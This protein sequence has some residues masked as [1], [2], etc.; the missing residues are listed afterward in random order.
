MGRAAWAEPAAWSALVQEAAPPAVSATPDDVAR[1]F[2]SVRGAPV[3]VVVKSPY[4]YRAALTPPWRE[5][6]PAQVCTVPP[7]TTADDLKL[8]QSYLDRMAKGDKAPCRVVRLSPHAAY[9]IVLPANLPPQQDWVLNHRA[10]LTIH[11]ASDFVFDG[12]GSALFFTGSTEG[13]DIENSARGIIENLVVDWGHPLDPNPAWRGPLLDAFGTIKK[14]SATSG[15]IELDPSMQLPPNF[16]PVIYTFHLWN[17][18]AGHMAQ[19][20]ELPGPTDD[21]CDASCIAQK[22]S[23]TQ[24]MTLRGHAL[25]PNSNASGKWVASN[26]VQYPNRDVLVAFS[27]FPRSAISLADRQICG[28]SNARSIP[29]PIWA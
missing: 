19:E 24:A 1:S 18:A 27:R 20:D 10:H 13:I 28:S 25:Y 12:N 29:R 15:H 14:D 16:V 22:K 2:T 4:W 7:P 26:L 11:D 8:I 5:L 3:K 23:P 21:G 17:K 6:D 9:H